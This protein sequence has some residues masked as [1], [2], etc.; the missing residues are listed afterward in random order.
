MPTGAAVSTA[1][2]FFC[3][4][5]TLC[6]SAHAVNQCIERT[7]DGF[8]IIGAH[9]S[10]KDRADGGADRS[11][12]KTPRRGEP[13]EKKPPL[14]GASG[15]LRFGQNVVSSLCRSEAQNG[16]DAEGCEVAFA[17]AVEANP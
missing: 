2:C 12:P 6:R 16:I 10:P 11:A 3:S 14:A 4:G 1:G 7:G 8:C 17:I 5:S 9:N 13:R 15:G